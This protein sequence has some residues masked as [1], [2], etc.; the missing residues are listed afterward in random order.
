LN[1]TF[2]GPE[3]ELKTVSKGVDYHGN[4]QMEAADTE[5]VVEVFPGA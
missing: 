3:A 5:A 1:D 4:G 2:N